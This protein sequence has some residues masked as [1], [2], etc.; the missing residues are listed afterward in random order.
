MKKQTIVAAL[1]ALVV[2]IAGGIGISKIRGHSKEASGS[3]VPVIEVST[4][5]TSDSA[6]ANRFTGMV[7]PQKKKAN[8]ASQAE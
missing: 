6:V 7:E 4:L 5:G 3:A 2:V 1:A 8:A